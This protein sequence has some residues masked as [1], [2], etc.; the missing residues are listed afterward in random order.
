MVNLV[1]RPLYPR[2]SS[3]CTT[4]YRGLGG[5]QIRSGRYGVREK[6]LR[7]RQSNPRFSGRPIRSLITI[8]TEPLILSN[9]SHVPEMAGCYHGSLAAG[10][11]TGPHSSQQ[12][13]LSNFI[14]ANSIPSS[15]MYMYKEQP[16]RFF[17]FK[18]STTEVYELILYNV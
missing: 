14:Q 9:I 2:R 15:T 13:R 3:S 7:R 17:I 6:S 16:F 1:Q 8:L 11:A 10:F 18:I 12:W 5:P 4:L